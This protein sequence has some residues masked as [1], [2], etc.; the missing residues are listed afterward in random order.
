MPLDLRAQFRR[1]LRP[2]RSVEEIAHPRDDRILD[3]VA[4]RIDGAANARSVENAAP[5]AHHRV[6]ADVEV[7]MIFRERCGLSRMRLGNH[8]AR[9]GKDT[10]AMGNDNPRVYFG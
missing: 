1:E 4:R 7:W 3:E 5:A 2:H 10:F 6:K 8:Q 9:T